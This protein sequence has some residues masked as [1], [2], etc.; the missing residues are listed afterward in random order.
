MKADSPFTLK[1]LLVGRR[2]ALPLLSAFG[3]FLYLSSSCIY[4]TESPIPPHPVYYQVDFSSSVGKALIPPGGHLRVERTETANSA[5]GYGGL[6]IIHSLLQNGVYYAYDLSCPHERKR[7]VKVFVNEQYEAE[8][9]E[10]KSRFS[11]QYGDGSPV[12][13]PAQT[14]L[15]RYNVQSSSQGV[16]VRN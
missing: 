14:P 9:P 8:C 16:T 6:L 11:I 15:R 7:A 10:C 4:Q 1:R 12:A 3:L 13:P 2:I 5:I